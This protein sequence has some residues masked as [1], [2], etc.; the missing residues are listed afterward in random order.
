MTLASC[1]DTLSVLGDESRLRLCALLR[2][3]ELRVTELVR[4]TGISQSRVS[5]HLARLRDAGFVH[6]RREAQH[7]F[8]TLSSLPPAA[9]VILEEAAAG[10]DPTLEGDRRRLRELDAERRGELPESFAGK[11]ELHY[12]PGRT[13]HSLASGLAALLRLGD[14]LDVG[15]GDGAVAAQ[16]AS[17]CKTLTAVD[18]S[19]KMIEAAKVRLAPYKNARALAVDGAAL[20]FRAGSF[21]DV[22]LFHTLTYAEEPARVLSECAR[23]LRVGGRL[24]VL[25]LDRHEH[26]SVTAPFGERQRGFAPKT[27]RSMI[28][29]T[30]LRVSECHVATREPKKPHFQVVLALGEKTES[31]RNKP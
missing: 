13:W 20:P 15:S 10:T 5:T 22:L 16:I 25:S 18:T 27:L 17:R 6:D 12:S 14:V 19:A 21:D 23:V 11:M 8:Y 31:E 9:R 28:Q 29:R 3:R 30:G 26:E 1:V 2:E 7:A 4:V 24:T